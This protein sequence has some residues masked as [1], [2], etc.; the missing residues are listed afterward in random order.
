MEEV[1]TSIR[2]YV[3]ATRR[4]NVLG[5]HSLDHFA[6][7]VP[8]LKVAERFY[9]SF[10]LDVR[11]RGNGLDLQTFGN[12]HRWI[13]LNEGDHKAMSYLSFGIFA[14]DLPRFRKRLEDCSVHLLDPPVGAESNG[15]WFR[16]CNGLLVEIK[17]SEKTTLNERSVQ[18][19]TPPANGVQAAHFKNE[20]PQIRPTRLAHVLVFVPD[21]AK[22]VSFY[23]QVLGLKLSDEVGGV[24]AFMH[25]VHGS[26]HHI[27]AFS[28]STA[29]GLHHCSW[30][31]GNVNDVGQGA[32]QMA[33]RGFTEGWGLGRFVL[34]SNFFHYVR[35]PWGSYSEYVSD[36][37]YIPV[38]MD[39]DTQSH[40][41]E[42][43]SYLWGPAM[44]KDFSFNYE[45]EPKA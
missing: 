22:S 44:P 6:F 24:V 13:R 38:N 45:A 17:V 4:P 20:A 39:Y 19:A 29:V 41:P 14:D 15:L 2:G 5:V 7:A 16:D 34:G 27:F 28:K 8:S 43:A 10:G 33:D 3:T 26:D 35:D 36:V 21:V 1:M 42:K 25:A 9:S 12:P 18:P 31:V 37:D 23:T 11:E 40:P 30:D 32:M